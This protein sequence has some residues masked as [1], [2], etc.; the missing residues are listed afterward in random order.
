MVRRPR[1]AR[2]QVM[3]SQLPL[4]LGFIALA[5]L[6][7]MPV[8]FRML[9]A[10]TPSA[11]KWGMPVAIA[12]VAATFLGLYV[13]GFLAGDAEGDGIERFAVEVNLAA[14]GALV[15]LAIIESFDPAE[16]FEAG[17]IILEE[18]GIRMD[19]AQPG[20][21]L[22]VFS[23]FLFAISVVITAILK[24]RG[25]GTF[26]VFLRLFSVMIVMTGYILFLLTIYY[27]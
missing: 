17:T 9:G 20:V 2:A 21:V 10:E 23:L 1:G 14:L 5:A 12:A 27:G 4:L 13:D 19:S 8:L 22:S 3:R 25:V 18:L 7:L 15:S 24:K 16:R 6:A 11:P 26:A